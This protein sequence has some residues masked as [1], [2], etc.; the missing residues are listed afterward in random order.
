MINLKRSGFEGHELLKLFNVFIRPV[1][2]YCSIIYHPLLTVSQSDIIEKMQKQIVKLAFGWKTSYNVICAEQD[3][4]TLKQRRVDYIDRFVSKS[5]HNSRFKD[6]W[7][8]LREEAIYNLRERNPYR[9]TKA[10]T[11]R[12]YNSPLSY[13]RRRANVLHAETANTVAM[14]ASY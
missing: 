13:M 11:K 2:E 14:N 6:N 3:I 8:P 7:F 9:E 1:I 4:T 5:I 12:Y 10:R